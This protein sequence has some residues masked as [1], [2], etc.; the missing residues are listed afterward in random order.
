[1]N[2]GH[3]R[4]DEIIELGNDLFGLLSRPSAPSKGVCVVL[5]NAGFL[6]RSDPFRLHVRLARR[7]AA[8]G[9][10]VL[11]FDLPGVGDS[12]SLTEL[13]QSRLLHE[14]FDALGRR[15]GYT[16]LIVGGICG[17]ADLA[18]QASLADPRVVGAIL[19]DGLA[20]KTFSYKLGRL[21][22]AFRTP[23]S[24]WPDKLRRMLLHS[25]RDANAITVES[26]RGWPVPGVEREQL[27]T[28]SSRG[29]ELF[30]LYTG[31][32]SYFLHRGQFDE[33][34]GTAAR[35][36]NVQFSYWPETNHLFY[37]EADREELFSAIG[38]WLQQRL[39][40]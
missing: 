17:G 3:G 11:R 14:V 32:T 38:G 24:R 10:A 1:M 19:L 26:E 12:L 16:R 9:Y 13:P 15:T 22:R 25:P 30:F 8:Q 18:W 29:V 20:R 2:P 4:G 21:R 37:D 27:Q 40:D 39:P 36:A 34:F 28:L 7:L 5:L 6:P 35:S 33:T 31:D 23:L